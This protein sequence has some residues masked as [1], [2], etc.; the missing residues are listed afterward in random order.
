MMPKRFEISK[1]VSNKPWGDVDKTAIRNILVQGLEEGAEGVREAIREVYAVIRGESLEDAPSQ[2]WVMPHHEVRDDGQIV[3][4]R[5]GLIAAAAA[6]A[7]ARAEPSLT[8]QQKRQA[9]KHLARHYREL[10]MELPESLKEAV[11]EICAVQAIISGEMQVNDVPLAPW[12]DLE[13]L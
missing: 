1:T 11:G 13:A 6:L 8:P 10:E 2:N 9:A 3:I 12:V 5:N 7:G 4:N